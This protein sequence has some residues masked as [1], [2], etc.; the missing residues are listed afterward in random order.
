MNKNGLLKPLMKN[1]F[2]TTIKRIKKPA[3]IIIKEKIEPKNVQI[4]IGIG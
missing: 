1:S 3:D 2:S 4:K